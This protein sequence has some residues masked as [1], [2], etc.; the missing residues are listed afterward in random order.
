MSEQI[1]FDIIGKHGMPANS[2]ERLK[3]AIQDSDELIGTFAYTT[4]PIAKMKDNEMEGD[5]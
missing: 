5:I 3:K 4:K 2:N 1:I